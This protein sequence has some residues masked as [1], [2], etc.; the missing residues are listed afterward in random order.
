[1]SDED[2]AADEDDE[3]DTVLVRE[4]VDEELVTVELKTLVA[5]VDDDTDEVAVDDT[6]LDADEEVDELEAIEEVE[7]VPLAFRYQFS[8]GSFR[9]SPTVTGV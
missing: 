7:E 4:V 2:G 3:L 6:E 9:H 1:M 5:G 8:G